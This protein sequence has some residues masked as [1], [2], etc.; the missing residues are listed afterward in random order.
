MKFLGK[1][2]PA[3][4]ENNI[5]DSPLYSSVGF[6]LPISVLKIGFREKMGKK[7]NFNN[8]IKAITVVGIIISCSSNYSAKILKSVVHDLDA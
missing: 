3:I 1:N 7:G 4:D 5:V 6:R 2:V 8:K